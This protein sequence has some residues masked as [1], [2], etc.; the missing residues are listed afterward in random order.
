LDRPVMNST[1]NVCPYSQESC[2]LLEIDDDHGKDMVHLKTCPYNLLEEDG[3]PVCGF[4]DDPSHNDSYF[5]SRRENCD[6]RLNEC[7]LIDDKQHFYGYFHKKDICPFGTACLLLNDPDHVETT[8]HSPLLPQ[9]CPHGA[10]CKL[11]NDQYH[12]TFFS[13]NPQ[14]P[15][16]PSSTI[17]SSNTLYGIQPKQLCMD[18]NCDK[19]DDP[20]HQKQYTHL[21]EKG[22]PIIVSLQN[23]LQSAANKLSNFFH[24]WG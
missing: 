12:G 8:I 18:K 2:A 15:N 6:K 11:M 16:T 19:M 1:E 22:V 7:Q 21:D 13:H 24:N 23:G 20:E 9:D 10:S 5:C 17:Q 3:S 4:Y 14:S